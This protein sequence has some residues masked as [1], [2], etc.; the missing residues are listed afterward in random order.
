MS[1]TSI[2]ERESRHRNRM[3]FRPL[4]DAVSEFEAA[5]TASCWPRIVF[6]TTTESLRESIRAHGCSELV[7]LS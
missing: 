4:G 7:N 5:R 3:L 2:E 6:A 1:P